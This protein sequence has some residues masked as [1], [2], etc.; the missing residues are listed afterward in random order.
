MQPGETISVIWALADSSDQGVKH[1]IAYGEGIMP[2]SQ[3]QTMTVAAAVPSP[4]EVQGKLSDQEA[5]KAAATFEEISIAD[6]EREMRVR[7]DN[8][9]TLEFCLES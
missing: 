1:N 5:L 3:E 8:E 4:R 7:G 2:L 9:N 6:L